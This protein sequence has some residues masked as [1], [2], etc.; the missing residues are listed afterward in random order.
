M[1]TDAGILIGEIQIS[2]VATLNMEETP[3]Q[4][5]PPSPL[6]PGQLTG[7]HELQQGL[8]V[9]LLVAAEDGDLGHR[10]HRGLR[11]NQH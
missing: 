2:R 10:P 1:T 5:P 7:V 6:R 4:E 3:N 9:G 11:A 8:R